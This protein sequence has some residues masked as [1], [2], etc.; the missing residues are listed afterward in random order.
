MKREQ[1]ET[2]GPSMTAK[3]S[4]FILTAGSICASTL[5]QKRSLAFSERGQNKILCFIVCGFS[6]MNLTWNLRNR[7]I[8]Q[9]SENVH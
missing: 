2:S 5:W 4:N 9:E 3:E 1:K 7:K 6:Y 8:R